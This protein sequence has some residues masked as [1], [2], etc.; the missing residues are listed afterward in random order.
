MSDKLL[1]AGHSQDPI[2]PLVGNVVC[3]GFLTYCL[4]LMVE[5]LPPENGGA[6]VLDTVDTVGDD[7]VIVASILN[8]WRVPAS[9]ISSP[10]GND[11]HGEKVIEHLRGMGGRCRTTSQRRINNTARSRDRGCQWRPDIF[12][13]TGPSRCGSVNCADSRPIVWSG[14]AIRGL[15]R[16]SERAS[17]DGNRLLPGH[18]C[19]PQPRV[20]IRQ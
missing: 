9:L 8:K 12:P 7:A 19:F 15:V 14:D 20:A 6:V 13:T 2:R 11:Y 3:F 10:V 18:I 1:P 4:L 5:H 17:S 16:W